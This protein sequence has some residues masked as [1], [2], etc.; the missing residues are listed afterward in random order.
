MTLGALRSTRPLWLI[1]VLALGAAVP[2]IFES[3]FTV[4]VISQILVFGLFA[5]SIDLLGGYGGLMPLGHAGLL[6]VAGYAV[7]YLTTTVD[8]PMGLAVA[9]ALLFTIA[10]SLLFGL[11]AVRTSGVSFTMITLAQGLIVWGLSIKLFWLTGA[12]NGMRGIQ[13]P[14][15]A[16]LY[17]QFYYLAFVVVALCTVLLWLIVRSPFGLT[18]QGLRESETRMRALGYDTTLHKLLTFSI[19]GLFCGVSGIL[20][21]WLNNFI[22]PTAVYMNISAEGVLMVILGGPGTIFGSLIGSAIV[23]SVKLILSQYTA[24]WPTVLGL[25]FVLTILF[26]RSGLLGL[27]RQYRTRRFQARM[28]RTRGVPAAGAA[29]E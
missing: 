5:M 17:W 10:I 6:G 16:V 12:E 26:A 20:Y 24:R 28:I 1:G 29:A 23:Q 8:L 25:I 22:S 3:S 15:F 4:R 7:G 18:I 2:Y 11:M 19:S 9:L 13:A 21:V 27:V 14:P